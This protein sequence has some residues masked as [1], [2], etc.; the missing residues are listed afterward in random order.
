MRNVSTTRHGLEQSSCKKYAVQR[1]TVSTNLASL[2]AVFWLDSSLPTNC[3]CVSVCG[4][5]RTEPKN[6]CEGG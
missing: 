1:S 3:V 5:G 4:E 2:V 6:G